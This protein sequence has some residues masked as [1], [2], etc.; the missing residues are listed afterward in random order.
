MPPVP[1]RKIVDLTKPRVMWRE[2]YRQEN[3]FA[4]CTRCRSGVHVFSVELDDSGK[5][6]FIAATYAAFWARYAELLPNE[7]HHYEVI[8]EHAPCKLYFDVEYSRAAHPALRPHE[9]GMVEAFLRVVRTALKE[10]FGVDTAAE[11][12]VDLDSSSDRKFSRHFILT[13][14]IFTD[15]I[16]MGHFVSG[17]L[18]PL[19]RA[20]ADA[21]TQRLVLP[22]E[23]IGAH[24]PPTVLDEGVYT[25]N[26]NFRLFL[27][28]KIAKGVVLTRASTCR[29]PDCSD[30]RFFFTSL[31]T[32]VRFHPGR[33]VLRNRSPPTPSASGSRG[34]GV[35]EAGVGGVR[36]HVRES[37]HSGDTERPR[38]GY[39]GSPYP[40]I[41][42]FI[43]QFASAHSAHPARVRRWA[44]YEVG[45]TL[46][47][48][49]A[50]SRYCE[51]IGREHK[52]NGVYFVVSIEPGNFY[53]K[54]YDPD[55]RAAN[56]KSTVRHIPDE[57]LPLLEL[58]A[59]PTVTDAEEG[60]EEERAWVEW[61]EGRGEAELRS[62]IADVQAADDDA[63]WEQWLA[64]GGEAGL[65]E[66]LD[67]VEPEGVQTQR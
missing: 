22:S 43:A 67:A 20:S 7:R 65:L 17:V 61:L 30:E 64:N 25:R 56:F 49:I 5:R 6:R 44:F 4:Y 66:A 3:A 21:A 57:C 53:Q 51:R 23:A 39:H 8:P 48:D 28:S 52:S 37:R 24:P 34:V 35:A 50:G 31:V 47:L 16:E 63:E 1:T 14:A 27:S 10:T 11:C 12:T 40:M 62:V 19:I 46:T 13:D 36:T 15:N 58:E 45:K 59:P 41:E 29:I 32:N 54:C 33:T 18:V 26:R 2:F 55:C 38:S 9:P 60:D 42:G